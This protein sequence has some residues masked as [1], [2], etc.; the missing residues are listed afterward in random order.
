M[1]GLNLE[2][3]KSKKLTLSS[4]NPHPS[5]ASVEPFCVKSCVLKDRMT[6]KE[7]LLLKETKTKHSTKRIL[8]TCAPWRVL[9]TAGAGH[10]RR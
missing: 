5:C 7:N 6:K 8:R 3:A 1:S 2:K 9:P 10:G 4:F